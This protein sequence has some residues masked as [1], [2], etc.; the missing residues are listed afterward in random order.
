MQCV[1]DGEQMVL[2]DDDGTGR[3]AWVCTRC[4]ATRDVTK[5]AEV[6]RNGLAAARDALQ[7]VP[8]PEERKAET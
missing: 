7:A 5:H 8:K 1:H 6:G 4:G 3:R 2:A